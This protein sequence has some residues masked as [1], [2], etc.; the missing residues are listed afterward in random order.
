VAGRQKHPAPRLSLATVFSPEVCR[1]VAAMIRDGN[2]ITCAAQAVG[3]TASTVYVWL[4]KGEDG[5]E[6]YV[7]FYKDCEMAKAFAE[8]KMVMI[9]REAAASRTGKIDW[10]AAAWWLARA[11]PETWGDKQRI[12][13]SHTEDLSQLSVE[14]IEQRL[15]ELNAG[16]TL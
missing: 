16:T 10:K 14:E 8:Q 4:R 5:H 3:V 13:I 2:S 1:Q 7:Q 12:D 15:A 6:T 9:V 11:R